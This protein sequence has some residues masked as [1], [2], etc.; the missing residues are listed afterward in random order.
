MNSRSVT[1]FHFSHKKTWIWNI[2]L[3]TSL[4]IFFSEPKNIT[5]HFSWHWQLWFEKKKNTLKI[6][7]CKITKAPIYWLLIIL[8]NVLIS[9]VSV[10]KVQTL[11]HLNQLL[12]WNQ[13]TL[14]IQC[15]NYTLNIS[16]IPVYKLYTGKG[17]II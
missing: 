5:K 11:A 12:A 8:I 15:I 14:N 9:I 3:Y 6:Y 10:T 1:H 13:L 7:Q 2:F 16:Y 4:W 17:H